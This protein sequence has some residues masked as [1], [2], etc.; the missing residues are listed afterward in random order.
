MRTKRGPKP[1]TALNSRSNAK[2]FIRHTELAPTAALTPAALEEFQRLIVVLESRG[3]LDRVDLGVITETARVKGLLDRAHATQPEDP[4]IES[5]RVVAMLSAQ[6]RGFRRDM[7]LN[8]LPSRS[9]VHS[10]G[11]PVYRGK[12][13]VDAVLGMVRYPED[14]IE[15]LIKFSD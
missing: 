8:L 11:R 5:V 9:V 13:G 10:T 12:D 1:R 15:K 14:P 2:G 4:D 3:T 7:G 6:L